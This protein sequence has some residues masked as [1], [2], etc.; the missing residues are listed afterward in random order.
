MSNILRRPDFEAIA[1]AYVREG[2]QYLWEYLKLNPL[3]KGEFEHFELTFNAAVTD[4]EV[5]HGFP[6]RP[7]DI[8]VT[9]NTAGTLTFDYANFTDQFIIFS[10]TQAGTVRFFGGR[11]E[12]ENV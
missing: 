4:V 11:Y 7:R 5:N 12:S 1:D 8:I 10:T 3:L 9:F 2:M 6:F